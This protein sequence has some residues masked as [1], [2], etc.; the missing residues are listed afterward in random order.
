M[1]AVP[2]QTHRWPASLAGD[3]GYS[4][5]RIRQ[6]LADRCI[7]DVIAHRS[8]QRIEGGQ[9]NFDRTSYRRR[10]VVERCVG[11]LEECRRV[12]TR[13][14][15]LAVNFLAMLELAIIERSLGVRA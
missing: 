9:G 10:N 13:F 8:D 4:D 3:K 11:W 7:R 1:E 15:K 2:I 14:D 12:T 6:W 5:P